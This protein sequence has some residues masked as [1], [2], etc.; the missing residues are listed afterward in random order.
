MT[1]EAFFK[2]RNDAYAL[3]K[4]LEVNKIL[5]QGSMCDVLDAIDQLGAGLK[6][7]DPETNEELP[8]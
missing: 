1:R 2:L 8:E 3:A 5:G 4:D 6:Y 7:L